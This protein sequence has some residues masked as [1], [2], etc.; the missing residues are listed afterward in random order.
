MPTIEIVSVNSTGMNLNQKDYEFA[1][2]EENKLVSHRGLF[3]KFL[4]KQK[5]V[6]VHLGD[7]DFKEEKDGFFWGGEL[8]DW[9]FEP[10]KI[11]FPFCDSANHIFESG[12]DQKLKFK[13]LDKYK[14]DVD[15]LLR[16]A[17]NCSPLK[18]SY[19]LTDYQFG[20]EREKIEVNYSINDFWT[21]HDKEGLRFNTL[22]EF[23]GQ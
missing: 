20:P 6:I 22:Y 17:L 21:E 15:K 16:K 19:F 18:K 8:I 14:T 2:I 10:V 1:I 7:P 13:I 23:Y 11:S 5:G 4:K 12:A 3:K 9:D